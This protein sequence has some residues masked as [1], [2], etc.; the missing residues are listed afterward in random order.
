MCELG[1]EDCGLSLLS[2]EEKKIVSNWNNFFREK[3]G[4]KEEEEI[5]IRWNFNKIEREEKSEIQD[6]P[7]SSSFQAH[8]DAKRIRTMHRFHFKQEEEKNYRN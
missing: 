8:R 4:T 1:R 3:S 7:P 6:S 2:L 5:Q